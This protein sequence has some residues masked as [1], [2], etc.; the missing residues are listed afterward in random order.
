MNKSSKHPINPAKLLMSKWTAIH[1]VNKEKHFL[2]TKIIPND[3]NLITSCIMEA[4][5]THRESLID[6]RDLQDKS[7]WLPGWH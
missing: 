3:E 1:P 4:V 2:I 5:L 7:C 6:W